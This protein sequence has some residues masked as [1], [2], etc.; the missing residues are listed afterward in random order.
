MAPWHLPP[1]LLEDPN[2]RMVTPASRDTHRTGNSSKDLAREMS[3]QH[4]RAFAGK[5]GCWLSGFTLQGL[6]GHVITATPGGGGWASG[7]RPAREPG[8]QESQGLGCTEASLSG[9]APGVWVWDG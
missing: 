3:F 6:T 7:D 2:V 8:Q 1:E 5:K 4:V 9:W